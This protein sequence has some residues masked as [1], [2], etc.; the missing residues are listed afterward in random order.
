MQ[1]SNR[2]LSAAALRLCLMA[3]VACGGSNSTDSGR[4]APNTRRSAD[5]AAT[6]AVDPDAAPP[7]Q[8]RYQGALQGEYGAPMHVSALL[9]DGSGAPIEGALLT[10]AVLEE[11]IAA[12]TSTTGEGHADL[13][14]HLV[15]G[16]AI[17]TVGFAGNATQGSA[18]T[19]AVISVAR[20][21]SVVRYAGPV[22]FDTGSATA[23]SATLRRRDGTPIPGKSL[24]FQAGAASATATTDA[25]GRASASMPAGA[26]PSALSVSFTGDTLF[27]PSTDTLEVGSFQQSGFVIW[28]GNPGGIAPGAHLNF[29]G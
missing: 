12:T 8:L 25:T 10:F 4:R 28:G 18:Q 13:V 2:A 17:M 29:W 23:V 19:T 3:M 9:T 7:L 22:F 21:E 14:P 5:V 26:A 24:S 27:A 1:R 15:D 16:A 6:C 20:A 11:E